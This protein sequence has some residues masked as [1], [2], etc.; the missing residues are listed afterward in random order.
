M[1][2]SF[3][4]ENR[5][6]KE[7]VM[8][9]KRACA[10]AAA[11]CI[12][13]TALTPS[14][15]MAGPDDSK[16]VVTQAH[17]DAPKVFWDEAAKNFTLKTNYGTN[18][19]KMDDTV[20]WVGQGINNRGVQQYIRHIEE[21]DAQDLSFLGKA[22]DLL[23]SAPA[24]PGFPNHPIWA[25]YGADT[26]IPVENFRER[27]F[28]LDLLSFDGPG[29]M[30]LFIYT[31]GRSV[32]VERMMSSHDPGRRTLFL[33]AGTHT[34]NE[35]TFT[36]PGRYE[37][38]Y[39][40]TARTNDGELVASQPQT[41]VWQVGGVSPGKG[42]GDVETAFQAASTAES[43]AFKPSFTLAP[44]T[45]GERDGDKYLTSLSFATGDSSDQGTAVFYIDGYYLTEVP[46]TNGV[47]T[48]NEMIG[49]Q[50][51]NFQVVYVPSQGSSPRWVSD[52]VSYTTG[53][54][55]ATTSSV[56]SFPTKASQDPT[57]A[58]ATAEI[59][60]GSTDVTVKA[61]HHEAV[62]DSKLATFSVLPE[63]D[64][65]TMRVKGGIYAKP[66]DEYPACGIDFVSA[67]GN[68]EFLRS[69]AYCGGEKSTL[70]LN[71]IPHPVDYRSALTVTTPNTANVVESAQFGVTK[72]SDDSKQP[73]QPP[74]PGEPT[75]PSE[76]A[77]GSTLLDKP[78]VLDRGHVDIRP[79][80][81]GD[82]VVMAIGDDS[83]QHDQKSVVR[84]PESVTLKVPARALK[85][86]GPLSA[87]EAQ[88]AG[89]GEPGFVQ[90]SYNFLGKP[91]TWLWVLPQ[92]Q[93]EGLVWPGFSTEG[94]SI[95]RYPNGINLRLSPVSVPEGGK[96]WAFISNF[97]NEV[98][99]L[100]SSE[101]SHEI[102]NAQPTHI[103]NYWAFTKPGKYV[104]GV[105]AFG[106]N[107]AG[108]FVSDKAHVTFQVESADRGP[109]A[110]ETPGEKPGD[111]S[112]KPTDESTP[113]SG[114]PTDKATD[115][116]SGQPGS[117][118]PATTGD[119]ATTPSGAPAAAS[120]GNST[121]GAQATTTGKKLP[122][123]GGSVV[124]MAAA[125]AVVSAM[126]VALLLVRKR[127]LGS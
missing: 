33:D 32:P 117:A 120:E 84:K 10:A 105:E 74:Q 103:H 81:S 15:A 27:A 109:Q 112:A 94:M 122:L 30:E 31:P 42:I 46:V 104:I 101:G 90:D 9:I 71:V 98:T 62:G 21:K 73:V 11:L 66:D 126:G 43:A 123:T 114:Q 6:R 67:P 72:R 124:S 28:T 76:S 17:V 82:D 88:K 52:A 99:M 45:E 44:Y 56:G 86:R 127:R 40:A 38:T 20:L 55:A 89:V 58:S 48:W 63:D 60:D 119:S 13:L 80:Q 29:R 115:K 24:N 26:A 96:W 64:R 113:P 95:D 91:G 25:G 83:R 36:R 59:L 93:E 68:R 3:R 85:I 47:A 19:L 79:F 51:S 7:D 118:N 53:Q 121:P 61:V 23:Y 65:M 18:P 77:P 92:A 1:L 54:E 35:T 37:I 41:L 78:V 102:V 49:S 14:I 87:E 22:G 107:A 97:S 108:E 4:N 16:T 69:V 116:P 2:D 75:A 110:G 57:P 39:R 70:K 111:P 34:H 8:H 5:Y 125:A 106:K 50:T 100:G 12:S